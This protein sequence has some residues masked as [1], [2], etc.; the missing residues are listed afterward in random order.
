[1]HSSGNFI[2]FRPA[3]ANDCA[4]MSDRPVAQFQDLKSKGKGEKRSRM[5]A[6]CNERLQTGGQCADEYGRVLH[7]RLP[8]R[9][10]GLPC[11][12]YIFKPI[13]STVQYDSGY[14]RVP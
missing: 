8:L 13:T 1:M 3:A 4:N 5:A 6:H 11:T 14:S 9:R 10:N 7:V 2:P 12:V